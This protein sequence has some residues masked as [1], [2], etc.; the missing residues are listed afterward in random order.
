M[1]RYITRVGS[2]GG[3]QAKRADPEISSRRSLLALS[4]IV[5]VVLCV[6][7]VLGLAKLLAPGIV[8]PVLSARAADVK[9][10]AIACWRPNALPWDHWTKPVRI[11][12]PETIRAVASALHG[13]LPV[14]PNHPGCAR[15]CDLE[16]REA[17]RTLELGVAWD[18]R[19]PGPGALVDFWSNGSWGIH[20]GTYWSAELERVLASVVPIESHEPAR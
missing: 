6:A 2:T 7:S 1:L 3:R 8:G 10:I 19:S 9:S 20:L 17:D 14:S 18:C 4:A 12:D 11:D 5:V 16:M 15:N 13:A